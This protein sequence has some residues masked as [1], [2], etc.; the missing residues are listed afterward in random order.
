[1]P[2]G[3]PPP[4]QPAKLRGRT[5]LRL[6]IIFFVVSIVLFV[7][8]GISTSKSDDKANKFQRINI[9]ADV[10]SQLQTITFSKAGGYIAYYEKPGSNDDKSFPRVDVEIRKGPNGEITKI[11]TPY[12]HLSNGKIKTLTYKTSKHEGVAVYQFHISDPGTYQAIALYDT[13]AAGSDIAIGTSIGKDTAVS[14]TFILIGLLLFVA[15][16]VLL[17]IGLVK[18]SRSKK[19]LAAVSQGYGAPGGYPPPPGAYPQPGQVAQSFGTPPPTG[20][21]PPPPP[22]G[23]QPPPTTGYEPPDNPTN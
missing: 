3:F 22:G 5:P 7:I 1:M 19:E 12:G 14:A 20:Y 4:A 2:G 16:I 17:I 13:P 23:Y 8:G 18:R 21:Q 10:P 15:A 6:A 11:D 9:T